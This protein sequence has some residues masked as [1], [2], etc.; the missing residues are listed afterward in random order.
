[1]KKAGQGGNPD[2]GQNIP[3]YQS[4]EVA[5]NMPATSGDFNRNLPVVAG[6]E[7]TTDAQGRFNLNALHRASGAGPNKAPG[8]WLRTQQAQ[9]LI[10][11]LEAQSPK[12]GFGD[13]TVQKSIVSSMGRNGGTFAAEE[14]AVSYAGWISPAYQLEV[15]RTFI[16]YR[17]GEL[18]VPAMLTGPQLMAAALIEADATMK[19]QAAQIE[20]M[21]EDVAAH[22]RLTKADGSLNVT[23]AAKNLGMRPKDLFDWLSHNGWIYKRPGSA[24]WLGYQPKCN[25]GL[26]EHKTT[27]VLR[28]DGSE[29]VT[30][31]V[32]ITP[33]GLSVLAKLIF[34]TARLI[35]GTA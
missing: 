23:E 5:M 32:R 20:A 33:K 4:K 28:A 8:Q 7:I 22:E 3:T 24:N 25:Q 19:R 13:D 31:Q 14:L 1:M 18:S 11:E 9:D 17:K 12:S 34:P 6:V 29:K 2:T 10:S 21:Q 15:N 35:G 30:E 27:T 26:L 16:A